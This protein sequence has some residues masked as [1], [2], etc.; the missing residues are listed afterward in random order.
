[1]I[2]PRRSTCCRNSFWPDASSNGTA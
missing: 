1:M 2:V